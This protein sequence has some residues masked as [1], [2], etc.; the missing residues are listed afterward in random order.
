MHPFFSLTFYVAAV[1]R[2]SQ[3]STSFFLSLESTIPAFIA[4]ADDA[5]GNIDESGD[6][7]LTNMTVTLLVSF[8]P[9]DENNIDAD[10]DVNT[11]VEANENASISGDLINA[12][13]ETISSSLLPIV[14]AAF[15]RAF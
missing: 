9:V 5:D 13:C 6:C 7:C 10:V 1:C 15:R 3:S 11:N 4:D 8:R 2:A 12:T 14:V